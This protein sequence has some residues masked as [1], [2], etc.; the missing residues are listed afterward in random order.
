V[1]LSK[2]KHYGIDLDG[3]C[4]DFQGGFIPWLEEHLNVK[5]PEKQEITS[6]YWYENVDNLEEK[7]FWDEFHKFGHADGYY[8]L[9]VIPGALEGLHR[10]V[11][12]G[13]K[14]TYITNRPTYA[15]DQTA[16]VLSRHHFPFAA[17]LEFAEGHKSPIVNQKKIDAFI[18]DSPTTVAELC[19][20]TSARIYCMDYPFNQDLH[21]L[22]GYTRVHSWSEFLE[23]EGI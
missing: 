9:E 19:V 22:T 21:N 12:A 14:I 13:H 6:Y 10:I 8:N 20:G 3:I 18:D 7:E 17:K 15:R 4:F 11:N 2:R 16:R 5:L 23:K 1:S